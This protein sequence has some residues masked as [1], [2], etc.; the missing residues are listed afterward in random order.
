MTVIALSNKIMTHFDNLRRNLN[1]NNSTILGNCSQQIRELTKSIEKIELLVVNYYTKYNDSFELEFRNGIFIDEFIVPFLQFKKSKIKRFNN[2]FI[3]EFETK[4]EIE[5]PRNFIRYFNYEL[6]T[7]YLKIYCGAQIDIIDKYYIKTNILNDNL[8][9]IV[10]FDSKTFENS[11]KSYE[12]PYYKSINKTCINSI[13]IEIT[14][15]DKNI[16]NFS[17]PPILTLHFKNIKK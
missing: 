10:K 8:L 15:S 5:L 16:V 12:A 2:Y 14:D 6:T 13:E 7:K 3:I 9:R 4:F 1:I 17:K 11:H